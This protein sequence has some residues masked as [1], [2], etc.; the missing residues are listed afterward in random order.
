ME[1]VNKYQN[2]KIYK[3]W[4]L[5]TDEIYVGST[6]GPLYKRMFK[7]REAFRYGGKS[8]Y[9]LYQEMSRLGESSF[10]IE[11]IE[12]YPCNSSDELHKREGHW[13]RELNST[14]NMV[15]AGR[16]KQEYYLEHIDNIKEYKKKWQHENKDRLRDKL[17]EYY[18]EHRQ[19][20]LARVK[21]YAEEHAEDLKKYKQ[22]YREDNKEKIQAKRSEV[23]VCPICGSSYIHNHKARHERTKKHL[24]ALEQ[25]S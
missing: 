11:L 9:K 1:S 15:I 13:I 16:T 7:H 8:H 17:K 22:Q 12:D 20:I 19:D 3:I 21:A 24:H 10:K 4:S 25:Q 2:G 23:H 6:C 14:L 5:E 18:Q